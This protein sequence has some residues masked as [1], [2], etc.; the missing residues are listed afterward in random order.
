MRDMLIVFLWP[1]I[2]MKTN[3]NVGDSLNIRQ[4]ICRSEQE[5]LKYLFLSFGLKPDVAARPV[6]YTLAHASIC[7]SLATA[8]LLMCE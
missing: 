3:R 2:T 4:C 7:R 6:S 5:T 8:T 1:H